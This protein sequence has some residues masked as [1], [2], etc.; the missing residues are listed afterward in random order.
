MIIIMIMISMINI[1]IVIIIIIIIIIKIVMFMIMI[2]G[3][4][5]QRADQ[6]HQY[7]VWEADRSHL[8]SFPRPGDR[9]GL[10]ET[11]KQDR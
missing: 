6:L 10:V 9:S 5:Q 4:E 11:E 8:G 3:C 1:I 7:P 2:T